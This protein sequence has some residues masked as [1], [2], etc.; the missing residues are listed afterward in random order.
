[1]IKSV[2]N[3]S[4][5]LTLRDTKGWDEFPGQHVLQ[6][7]QA[8]HG[9]VLVYSVASRAS[10]ELVKSCIAVKPQ[11]ELALTGKTPTEEEIPISVVGY[12]DGGER[13]EV[14]NAEGENLGKE[15]VGVFVEISRTNLSK[16]ALIPILEVIQRIQHLRSGHGETAAPLYPDILRNP[17]CAETPEK[18]CCIVM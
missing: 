10:F 18:G 6:W 1:M 5:N 8:S 3:H 9:L 2:E 15:L 16:K 11:M 13:R 14:S 12:V 17:G 4:F 7:I